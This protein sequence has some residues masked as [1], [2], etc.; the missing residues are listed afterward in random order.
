MRSRLP[1]PFQGVIAVD[2]AGFIGPDRPSPT[3]AVEVAAARGVDLSRHRS[4]LLTQAIVERAEL[5]CVMDRNQ[6]RAVRARYRG[7]VRSVILL[8]D[9]DPH[10]IR[11]RA[12][13]DPVE[14]PTDVF[15][16]VYARIDRCVAQLTEALTGVGDR[17]EPR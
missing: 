11:T 15:L 8:G 3:V 1:K 10:P 4:K 5:I 2:S 9:L 17:P 16:E 14:R 6:H 12:I 7:G 13:E